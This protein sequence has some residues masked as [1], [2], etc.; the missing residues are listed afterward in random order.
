MRREHL[1]KGNALH[2]EYCYIRSTASEGVTIHFRNCQLSGTAISMIGPRRL[3]AI[4]LQN[5]NSTL[6]ASS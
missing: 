6:H 1:V 4:T 3:L 2:P 5:Q